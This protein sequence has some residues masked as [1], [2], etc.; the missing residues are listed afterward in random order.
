VT[1]ISKILRTLW[2]RQYRSTL[3]RTLVFAS[4]EH[5][6]IIADL[7]LDTVVDIG[8]NRGQFAL[9]IRRLYPEAEIFSFEPLAKAATKYLA[10]FKGDRRTH[11]FRKAVSTTGGSATL[12]V[13]QWDV[14]SSLL[15][16][17]EAQMN[18]FPLAKESRQETVSLARLS[19]C[20]EAES[21]AGTALLKL[22]VQGYELSALQ[23]CE[24][25][26]PSFTYVYLEA[27]FIELYV[28]QPLAGD[29]IAY[30]SSHGFTLACVANLSCGKSRRPI[31]ADF[32][33]SRCPRS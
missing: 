5:D 27:S 31:Q 15:P 18:N 17:A 4:S 13:T 24:D 25:L 1:I 20:V 8:A 11:L 7:A 22:D 10:V 3:L 12:H 2:F 28:G 33:F 29:L 30:L 14:S 6:S 26:L 32:L 9:C 21:I 23:G 16:I 19:D